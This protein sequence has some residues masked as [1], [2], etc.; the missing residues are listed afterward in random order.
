MLLPE[1]LWTHNSDEQQSALITKNHLNNLKEILF[2]AILRNPLNI[3]WSA[4]DTNY[5]FLGRWPNFPPNFPEIC[6]K[7]SEISG[8]LWKTKDVSDNYVSDQQKLR[9]DRI[10]S[11]QDLLGCFLSCSETRRISEAEIWK[12]KQISLRVNMCAK[13]CNAVRPLCHQSGSEMPSSLGERVTTDLLSPTIEF[14][15]SRR[16]DVI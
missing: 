12:L 13:R 5:F 2:P 3:A 4:P 9:F 11:L 6:L 8:R 15:C 16:C 7:V 14:W 1:K 10:P